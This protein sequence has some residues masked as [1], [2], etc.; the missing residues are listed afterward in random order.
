MHLLLFGHVAAIAIG[1]CPRIFGCPVS[2]LANTAWPHFILAGLSSLTCMCNVLWTANVLDWQKPFPHSWHLNGFSLE[3]MYL[4][5]KQDRSMSEE[6]SSPEILAFTM[7]LRRHYYKKHS[8]LEAECILPVVSEMVLSPEGLLADVTC[9]RP[10]VCVCTLMDQQ[11][12]WFGEMPATKLTHKL[13]LGLGWQSPSTGLPL[14]RS[15]LCHIQKTTQWACVRMASTCNS[16]I[17]RLNWLLLS[18]SSS[19][20]GKIE[21]RLTFGFLLGRMHEVREE[22]NGRKRETR[23]GTTGQKRRIS[24]RPVMQVDGVKSTEAVDARH[25]IGRE[26]EAVGWL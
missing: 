8:C 26:M 21:P 9:I 20:V 6:I 24:Q 12:V 14:G 25:L 11:V 5:S 23:D 2:P 16:Q 3:W 17:L 15:Q 19:Q 7:A 10:L 18:C 13:L 1:G 22:R 4:Q